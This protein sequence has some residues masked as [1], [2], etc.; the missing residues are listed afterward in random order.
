MVAATRR[1]GS[2]KPK[3]RH[4]SFLDLDDV[5]PSPENNK[6]YRPVDPADPEIIALAESIRQNGLLEPIVVTQDGYIVSGHRRHAAAKLAGLSKVPVRRESFR[7]D[8]DIDQFVALLREH[9]RQRTKSLDEKLREEIV[10]ADPEEAHQ[11]LVEYRQEQS[12]LD[13]SPILRIRGRKH[14]SRISEAKKPFLDAVQ[15]ILWERREYLPLSVR[16]VHYPLLNHPPLIHASKPNSRYANNRKSYQ[17]LSDLLTRARIADLI[18]MD[19]ISDDTRPVVTWN[20]F[21]D[22][23]VFMRDQLDGLM[24]GY[25]RDLMQSQPNHIEI[26]GEKNTVHSILRSVAMEYCIPLTSGRGFASLP[27]RY[28][29]EERFEQSGK[30]QLVVL[31]VTDFDPDGEEIAHSFARSMRDDFGIDNIHPIKVALTEDQVS[32]YELPPMMKA[33]RSST[34]YRRF[35]AKYGDDVFELEALEPNDLQDILRAAIDSV[36]DV[37]AFNHEIDAEKLDAAFLDV[38]RQKAFAAI[39][40]LEL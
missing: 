38:A 22:P 17:S 30:E 23:S 3:S 4:V 20:V 18:P 33:K 36:I 16:A 26:V 32:D 27:P 7:R 11:A 12:A 2:R 25:W 34:N 39:G 6:I 35:S 29:M 28:R 40:D 8:D 31:F 10:A 13:T 14:R 19:W 24:K 1:N 15:K 9:N 37:D 5:R 21:S